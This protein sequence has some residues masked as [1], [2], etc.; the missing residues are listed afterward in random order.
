MVIHHLCPSGSEHKH[1][2]SQHQTLWG[3]QTRRNQA[4]WFYCRLPRCIC[5]SRLLLQLTAFVLC[6]P[7]HLRPRVKGRSAPW[8]CGLYSGHHCVRCNH[9]PL[10]VHQ[11]ASGGTPVQDYT[12]YR[13]LPLHLVLHPQRTTSQWAVRC[14]HYFISRNSVHISIVCFLYVCVW[15]C[16]HLI[17]VSAH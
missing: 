10:W 13:G 2:E 6:W 15:M 16:S 3:A 14:E 8:G 12:R 1:H 5:C 17:L 7:Q 11:V 4:S 9:P